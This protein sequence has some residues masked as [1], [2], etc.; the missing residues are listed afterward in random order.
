MVIH[1]KN[2]RLGNAVWNK[3]GTQGNRWNKGQLPIAAQTTAF[4]I[5]FEGLVGTG[6][7]GDIGLDDIKL[8][9]GACPSA[10]EGNRS[11]IE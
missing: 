10:G 2:G 8:I 7:R 9:T 1:Q 11:Y 4:N 3:H 6:Y 5:V